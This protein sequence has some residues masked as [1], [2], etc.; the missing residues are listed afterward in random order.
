MND[1]VRRGIRLTLLLALLLALVSANTPAGAGQASQPGKENTGVSANSNGKIVESVKLA[2]LYQDEDPPGVDPELVRKL[3]RNARGS[4]SIS[5]KKSTDMASFVQVSRGGDLH[6]GNSSNTPNGKARGFFAEYGGLFGVRNANTELTEISTFT[7]GHGFTHISYRQVYRGVPVFAAVLQAHVSSSNDLTAM[8]GVFIP[9]INLDTNPSLNRSE[10]AERALADVRANPPQNEV[11][12]TSVDVTGVSANEVILYVYRDGLIQDVE[13]PNLLVYEVEVTNGSSVREK[14]YVDAHSGKI[15]N[16]I[17]EVHQALFRRLFEE[18]TSNQVWQEG[19]PF[20]GSLN[21]DQANIVDFSGDSYYHFFNAFGVD[22]YDNAGAEM[23]SVNND[24]RISCPN[25]NWNGITTNYCNGVT[26]D[27]VVAHEWGHA[28]TDYTHDLI[29]QWQSGALNESYS[30][31]WGEVVDMLNGKGTDLPD[32]VRSANA[33][34]AYTPPVPQLTINSPASIAGNYPAGAAQF[35]PSLAT[36]SPTGNVVLGDDGDG[37]SSDACTPLVNGAA[38]VGNIALVD[39]GTCAFTIKVKNAQDA[40][41]I[42]VIVADNVPG[43][44]A[45]MGGV[46]PSIVIPSLRVTLATGN[47]IKGELANGAVNATLGVVG[48]SA[49]EDSYRWLMGEDSTAFGGAIRDMWAPTCMSDP[50]KVTDA[51]YHCASSDGGGVHTNS[52]VPNHG[53]ALLVDGGSYNGQT[54]NAIGMV[55]AAHLYWR[56]QAVYQTPTTNFDGHAD[57]LQASCQD[58]IGV[59]LEGLSTGSSPAGPSGQ[60]ITAADCAAVDAMIDAVELRVDPAAQCNFQPILQQNPP[61]LCTGQ[62]NPAVLYQEDFEDGLAEWTLTNQGVFAGWPDLDWELSSSL[63]GDRS[64][65]AAFAP[66]PI[67][68]NCD[69]GAGDVSGVM[70]LESPVIH[71]PNAAVLTPRLTFEH[72]VATEAGWD[73]GNLRIS[74]NGG[75]YTLVPSSAY[76]FNAYNTTLQTAAAGNTNP[77]AGQ[78]AY[79]GTD[80]GSLFGSWGQSQVNLAALGVKPGDN[81]R[82]RYDFGMDGCNGLD[83]WYVDNVTIAACN[84]NRGN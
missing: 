61:A 53:F 32:T 44:A 74:I 22:S 81:I 45:G 59:P 83:G 18:N 26:S 12:G 70:Y 11:T 52:G 7:D 28:Y 25:A 35:G 49:P 80:G 69:G 31:I 58:L 5:T 27:D 1:S 51:Q 47:L 36:V 19:D 33:C 78:P 37:V 72:Y 41:A 55:K 57:A 71:I 17:S 34:T 30:D 2:G 76:T 21:Q 6:P 13:G 79:S 23:Q 84:V 67:I 29:Y 9:D 54:V 15:V 3:R 4:V 66:D 8:N 46:D 65:S 68:G 62:R 20:P 24:P 16:R 77:L 40:G 43:P 38:V 39:R 82:L 75:P 63:P 56:A 73:G 10:A 64:G 42:G 60:S 50:G 48:G 14:V